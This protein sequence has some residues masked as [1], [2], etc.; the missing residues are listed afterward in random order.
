MYRIAL[1]LLLATSAFAQETPTQA[2]LTNLFQAQQVLKAAET[3]GAATTAKSLYDEAAWRL[4]AA[5][6][7]WNAAKESVREQARLR[8][9]EALWAGR[10]ALSKAQWLGTTSAIRSLQDD[11][12]RFGGTSNVSI[13]EESPTIVFQRGDTSKARVDFAQSAIDQAKKAGGERHAAAD[14]KQAQ[15]Y[16]D[17]A[18]KA[19]RGSKDSESA[20]HLAFLAEMMAR[21]AFY[22]A[23]ANEVN[24]QLAPLQTERSR[25]ARVAAEQQ[26]AQERAQR[27]EAERAAAEVQRQLAAEQANRE[28]QAA[29]L[30]RLRQQVNENQR[31]MQDRVEQDRLAREQAQRTLDEAIRRYE[32]AISTAAPAEIEALRRQVED[33]QIALRAMQERERLN[34]QALSQ[35]IEGLRSALETAR[36]QGTVNAQVLTERET[37]LRRR[38]EE[39]AQLK[40]DRER[41]LTQRAE[42]ERQQ[43]AAIAD[44]QRKR[45]ELEAQAQELQKAV[46]EA[47]QQAATAQQQAATAQQQAAQTQA[48]LERTRQDLAARDAEARQLRMQQ[49]LGRIAQTRTD[50]RGIIVTLPGIFFDSGK[51]ALKP[52]AKKTLAKI[53][54]QLKAST[55]KIAVEGHTDSVGS[56]E[57]N[58]RLSEARAQAVRDFLTSAGVPGD[59]ISSTGLGEGTPIAT[60]NTAAGRQQNRRVELVI[61]Q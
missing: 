16:V 5:E 27:E 24:P 42:M 52:G 11:I 54:E 2:P 18:R 43:Q 56:E 50:P 46:Q 36:Q 40:A 59:S 39:L 10:A 61:T 48:E 29:E 26:A 58:M 22:L 28:A 17:S 13:E 30:D 60:N 38:Q 14:L 57:S 32:A 21:R 4:R 6:E 33:Q 35:E 12:R 34:E 23:R 47:Q 49:E 55:A 9:A 25:L 3:A 7:N 44:A 51:S 8:A 41:E 20:D 37:E 31:V 45:Q 19:V 1:V 15:A 53:A